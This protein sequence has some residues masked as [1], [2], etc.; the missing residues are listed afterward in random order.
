LIRNF[1]FVLLLAAAA[2]PALAQS[3]DPVTFGIRIEM[4]DVAQARAWLRA[5]LHPDTLADRIGTGL[6]IAA[7]RGDME[8]MAL[9]VSSG[10]DVNK[11]NAV[12]ETALMHAAWQG[13]K[14]AVEWLLA[15]GARVDNAPGQWTALHYAA[16]SGN[17]EI[18]A[19]LLARGAD[20]NARAPNGSSPLMMAVYEGH[21]EMVKRLLAR[22]ADAAVKNDRGDG[23]LEWAVKFG[24]RN[25]ARHV[26]SASA[27]AAASAR[28]PEPVVR[29]LPPP[30]QAPAAGQISELMRM[31]STLAARGMTDSVERLDRRIAS[32]RAQQAREH[33]RSSM[34]FEIT[35]RRAAPT[36]QETR[37]LFSPP[38][39][40]R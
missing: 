37:L 40:G 18:A 7:W 23:A 9:F 6:M 20:I 26:G 1:I 22:G 33:A 28:P 24:H 13:Q 38:S 21:E 27:I 11:T 15:R 4:G 10:A 19:L 14:Q 5:G 31:R 2:R 3:P 34:V 25:I 8:M 39:G 36:E 30:A 17:E 29:S 32:L 12:G 35:A 16:F